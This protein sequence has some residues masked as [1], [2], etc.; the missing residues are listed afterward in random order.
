MECQR[1]DEMSWLGALC[2]MNGQTHWQTIGA[3][4]GE[5]GV[6]W[7]R[8]SLITVL[9]QVLLIPVMNL[10]QHWWYLVGKTCISLK[11]KIKTTEFSLSHCTTQKA[12]KLLSCLCHC[13]EVPILSSHWLLLPPECLSQ[14]PE[15]S[16]RGSQSVVV[17]QGSMK[18]FM[19][20]AKRIVFMLTLATVL[21]KKNQH[22]YVVV[23]KLFWELWISG[24]FT[25]SFIFPPTVTSRSTAC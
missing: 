23:V 7:A 20:D 21:V 25:S 16:N 17:L 24:P 19:K 14:P 12:A 15:F 8:E 6:F 5:A 18:E 11:G 13:W 10:L 4:T 9:V 1:E 3:R 22:K 2:V